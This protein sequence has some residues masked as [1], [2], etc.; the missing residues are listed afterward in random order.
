MYYQ[1]TFPVGNIPR[2][3]EVLLDYTNSFVGR[4]IYMSMVATEIVLDKGS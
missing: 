4:F 3:D 2:S 1:Q